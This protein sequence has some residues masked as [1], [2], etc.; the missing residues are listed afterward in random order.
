MNAKGVSV[1]IGVGLVI[2]AVVFLSNNSAVPPPQIIDNTVV[3]D[4]SIVGIDSETVDI[5]IKDNVTLEFE[6]SAQDVPTI[7]DSVVTEQSNDINFYF[8]ENGTKHYVIIVRDAP[9]LGK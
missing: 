1:V 9:L 6:S 4:N 8:D 7:S 3:T 2:L 5:Q